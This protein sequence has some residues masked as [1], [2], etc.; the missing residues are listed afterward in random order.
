MGRRLGCPDDISVADIEVDCLSHE[1]HRCSPDLGSL[2]A[3]TCLEVSSVWP[4][5]RQGLLVSLVV[6][7]MKF[8]TVFINQDDLDFLLNSVGILSLDT[9]KFAVKCRDVA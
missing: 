6:L 1:W 8:I 7:F 4:W 2:A 3:L 9:F 5:S